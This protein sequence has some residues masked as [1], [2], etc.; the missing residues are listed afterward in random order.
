MRILF[1]RH[2]DPDYRHDILTEAG[3]DQAAR[4]ADRLAASDCGD[5]YVSPLGRAQETAQA[6]LL[7]T[8][9]TAETLPWLREFDPALDVNGSPE[10]QQAYPDSV[11]GPDERYEPRICWDVVPSYLQQHP[12][13][14]SENGWRDSLIARRS[15]MV[16]QYDWVAGGLDQLLARYH[17]V[18][19][20]RFYRVEAGSHQT[21][22]LFCHLGVSGVMMSHLFSCSP[23]LL[24]QSFCM[25]T[26]SITEVVS[27]ERQPG[28]ASFR[29][30][31]YSDTAHLAAPSFN[32]RFCECYDDAARH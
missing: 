8:G 19:D 9:R 13:L 23:F 27:E 2:A 7:K 10:L 24:W 17:Y 32:A 26:A 12:E 30:L 5:I 22:T 14:L 28:L 31:H 15:R 21:I 11:F 29:C 25:L 1:I 16:S 4:L 20:G 6:Y 18:R 3:L